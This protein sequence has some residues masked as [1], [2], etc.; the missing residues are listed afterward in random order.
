MALVLSVALEKSGAWI[1]QYVQQVGEVLN[2]ASL[3][4]GLQFQELGSLASICNNDSQGFIFNLYRDDESLYPVYDLSTPVLKTMTVFSEFASC[5]E[6][7]TQNLG[8]EFVCFKL[9]KEPGSFEIR[10][11]GDVDLKTSVLVQ[12][13]L[14]ILSYTR[15]FQMTN[16]RSS[17][18]KTML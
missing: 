3:P 1:A 18:A 16:F 13:G 2:S 11:L 17:L 10:V 4:M 12:A 9:A 6:I 7:L 15:G 14:E 8:L 5:V